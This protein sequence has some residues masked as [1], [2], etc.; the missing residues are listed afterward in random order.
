MKRTIE[1]LLI[2]TDEPLPADKI[3]EIVKIPIEEIRRLINELN[4]EYR[5][6]SR[7]F[8]IKEIAGGFQI[9]TL[10]EF[11]VAVSALHEKKSSLSKA[12]LE[13]IAIIAYHQPITRPEIEKLRGV[14]STG[15]LDTLLQKGLVK[16]CGRLPVP[17]RPI[18]YATTREFLRYFGINDISE[19]PGEE[20]FGARVAGANL[21][22]PLGVVFVVSVLV[23]SL[24]I[25]SFWRSINA[26]RG[27]WFLVSGSLR[28]YSPR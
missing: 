12:A 4:E 24:V 23:R 5:S 11:A 17:G 7:A 1:A 13:T 15:V 8:E 10:P 3:T 6:T 25:L 21:P 2:A 9:Y 16:T 19:L 20:E 18:R 14:D 27:L 26:C 22:A 28:A